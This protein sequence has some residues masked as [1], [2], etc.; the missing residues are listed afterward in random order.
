MDHQLLRDCGKAIE[1]D[2]RLHGERRPLCRAPR[3]ASWPYPRRFARRLSGR[4][5]RASEPPPAPAAAQSRREV[6]R[7]RSEA[8][9][10]ARGRTRNAAGGR[11]GPPVPARMLAPRAGMSCARLS[12]IE[13]A[14]GDSH[15]LRT[16]RAQG[17]DGQTHPCQGGRAEGPGAR[18]L[19]ARGDLIH[20]SAS[21]P[22]MIRA[23]RISPAS[24]ARLSTNADGAT[25]TAKPAMG[26]FETAPTGVA[27]ARLV[28]RPE[29]PFDFGAPLPAVA[30]PSLQ[31]LMNGAATVGSGRTPKNLWN[32]ALVAEV[33]LMMN[34]ESTPIPSD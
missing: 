8:G 34:R 1:I 9:S 17:G 4:S 26:C 10:P 30:A 3:I 13:R 24:G 2:G 11:A 32:D 28:H 20:A 25:K 16:R 29:S 15:R 12:D 6:R 7:S 5:G 27:V 21:A 33:R 19:A 23:S 31:Q 18:G 22:A 14:L